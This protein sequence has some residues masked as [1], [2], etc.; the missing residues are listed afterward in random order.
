MTLIRPLLS[1]V[2]FPWSKCD[3]GA[4]EENV[5]ETLL[6]DVHRR[7]IEEGLFFLSILNLA[8]QPT[9]SERRQIYL[10]C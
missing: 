1:P 6:F 3:D 4:N 7:D 5:R 10:I 8:V 2:P 9:S